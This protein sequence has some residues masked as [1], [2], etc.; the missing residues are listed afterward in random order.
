VMKDR[1]AG[2]LATRVAIY[3]SAWLGKLYSRLRGR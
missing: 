3:Q 1:P 2:W